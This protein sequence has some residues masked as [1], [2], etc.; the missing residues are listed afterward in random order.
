[1]IHVE[2]YQ[3]LIK[4][5]KYTYSEYWK[6]SVDNQ[7]KLVYLTNL[8]AKL[9]IYVKCLSQELKFKSYLKFSMKFLILKIGL[10]FHCVVMSL[11][12]G[13]IHHRLSSSTKI[14]E[15]NILFFSPVH[16]GKSICQAST[17]FF[18]SFE[19]SLCFFK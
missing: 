10:K 2:F 19:V 12:G 14:D 4:W 7:L 1:M 15:E 9:P 3:K 16:L 17:C 6:I 11:G 8:L 13:C 5:T 18:M